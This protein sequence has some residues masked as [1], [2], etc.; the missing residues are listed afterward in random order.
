MEWGFADSLYSKMV[1]LSFTSVAFLKTTIF[2]GITD[3]NL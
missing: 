2:Q 3:D 1:R